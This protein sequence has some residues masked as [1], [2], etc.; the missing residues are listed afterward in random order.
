MCARALDPREEDR[1]GSGLDGI[2]GR[3][4]NGREHHREHMTQCGAVVCR[5]RLGGRP[6]S[7]G[8]PRRHSPR[9]ARVRVHRLRV[10]RRQRLH[11]R[12]WKSCES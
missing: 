4:I 12:R 8:Q 9:G 6:L 10:A 1:T 5:P 11:L 2:P 7:L 3:R